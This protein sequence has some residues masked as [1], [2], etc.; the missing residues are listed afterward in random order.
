MAI[1]IPSKQI[2]S[3]ENNIAPENSISRISVQ[4]NIVN[5]VET[6]EDTENRRTN[7]DHTG[8]STTELIPFRKDKIISF[9]NAK[10]LTVMAFEEKSKQSSVETSISAEKKGEYVIT[11]VNPTFK[12]FYE[13]E[14]ADYIVNCY[15]NAP[16]E[17]E[18][19]GNQK[20]YDFSNVNLE[21]PISP[22]RT[23]EVSSY[24]DG[25]SRS[26]YLPVLVGDKN[27]NVQKL[28]NFT[29]N[30][31]IA[32]VSFQ[33]TINETENYDRQVKVILSETFQIGSKNVISAGKYGDNINAHIYYTSNFDVWAAL[34]SAS[35][36]GGATQEKIATHF[37]FRA[38]YIE[39]V[40]NE[41]IRKFVSEPNEKIIETTESKNNEAPIDLASNSFANT[42]EGIESKT[43]TLYRSTF[44]DNLNGKET[45][46][47]RCSINDYFDTEGNKQ[48]SIDSADKMLFRIGDKVVPM[49][50]NAYGVDVPMSNRGEEAIVYTVIGCK[51]I[52]NGAIWQELTLR[53]SGSI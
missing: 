48:I 12:V 16:F 3:K 42:T 1:I 32:E 53:E 25:I 37:V 34:N 11:D 44:E 10:F 33:N 41:T 46:T 29:L 45:A 31:G 7:I 22:K 51:M 49:L 28:I 19:S 13:A 30:N 15:P 23:F 9:E 20:R 21:R 24:S 17:T 4:E 52:F 38:K 14:I 26:E 39:I 27:T 43:T 50:R 47:V 2:Y 6:S 5:L 35:R 36:E 8:N 40:W 18:A